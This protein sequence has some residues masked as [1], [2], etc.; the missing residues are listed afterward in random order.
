MFYF[1]TLAVV[2][3][4]VI[5]RGELFY[6]QAYLEDCYYKN[7]IT[8]ERIDC[9][10]GIDTDKSE[11]SMKCMVCN[12]FYFKD[13]FKYQPRVCNGCHDFSMKVM[14][15]SDFFVLNV[16]GNDYRVYIANIDKEEAVKM[17]NNGDLGKKKSIV[18]EV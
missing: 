6:P 11:E 13:G 7:M 9:S 2:I 10:E 4:S 16:G 5:K 18:N 1:P 17:L 15:L 8:Y 14:E 3:R 12:Y